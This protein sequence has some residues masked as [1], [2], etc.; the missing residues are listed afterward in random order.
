M[1]RWMGEDGMEGMGPHAGPK[2]KSEGVDGGGEDV[3]AGCVVLSQRRGIQRASRAEG[4]PDRWVQRGHLSRRRVPSVRVRRAA[5]A[6]K[7]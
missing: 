3:R 7:P 1:G 6:L 5:I 2:V 4:Q